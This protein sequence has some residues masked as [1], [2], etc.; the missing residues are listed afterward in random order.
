[1][2]TTIEE[3]ID[4]VERLYTTLTGKRPP[5]PNGPRMPLSRETDPIAH[6]QDQL[7]RMVTAVEGLVPGTVAGSVWV[8]R[9]SVWFEE[10]DVVFALDVPGVSGNEV[11]IRV[12]PQMIAVT[13]QRLRP[14]PQ[15]PRTIRSCE[16]PIGAFARSFPLEAPIA[17]DRVSARIDDGGLTIRI[18]SEPRTEPSQI[19]IRS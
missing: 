19:S 2:T 6:V 3:T 1:M 18:H 4:R 9:T 7:G 16:T 13:G 14:W 8:P 15:P 11:Q 12:E 10:R 17:P 5:P